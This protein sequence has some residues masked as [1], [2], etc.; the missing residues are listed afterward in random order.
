MG[1]FIVKC[2]RILLFIKV[3]DCGTRDFTD[4]KRIEMSVAEFIDHWSKDSVNRHVDAT[5]NEHGKQLLYLKDWHF[6]KV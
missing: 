5:T 4:Q 2:D 3:A 6:V 1:S